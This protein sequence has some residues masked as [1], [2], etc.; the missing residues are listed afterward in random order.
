[1]TTVST[2]GVLSADRAKTVLKNFGRAKLSDYFGDLVVYRNLEPLDRR[3]QGRRAASYKMEIP[4][5]VIPRKQDRDYAKAAVWIARQA[6]Q[7]VRRPG[8]QLDEILFIGDTLYN[9]GH[10]FANM[11]EVSEWAGSC[12][13]GGEKLND[14]PIAEIGD[15]HV[16]SANRWA[17]LSD[18]MKWA[19]EQGLH[20]DQRTVVIVDIDKTALGAKGRNDQVINEARLEGIYRTMNAVLGDNFDRA[21]FESDYNELNRSRYH[22]LTE[23]NQDYLAY[24]CMA[25]NAGLFDH[26]EILREIEN[27][28]VDNFEQFIRLVNSRMMFGGVGGENLRQA[29]EAVSASVLNGDPTPFKRFRR[30]EFITTVERMGTMPDNTPVAELLNGE[31]TLTNEVCEVTEWLLGRGCL[32]LCMSDKPDEASRPDAHYSADL[33]PVHQAETHRVG[34]SIAKELKELG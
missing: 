9:D 28:S 2:T 19:L 17:A 30:E 33:P 8:A 15:G 5:D 32:L 27:G 31:I 3:I 1:V 25:L 20:V 6:A 26:A 14:A 13:I 11:V 7:K 21:T 16:Y 23:D 18:W 24:I 29:H 34:T 4:A 22:F 10:A 12:F